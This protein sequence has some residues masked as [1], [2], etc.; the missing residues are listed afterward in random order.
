MPS[1]V[2]GLFDYLIPA[3]CTVQPVVGA[4]VKASFGKRIAIGVIVGLAQDSAY[5]VEKLKVITELLDNEAMLPDSMLQLCEWASSY[6]QYPLGLLLQDIMPTWLRTDHPNTDNPS[7]EFALPIINAPLQLNTAQTQAVAAVINHFGNFKSFLLDGIT[8]SGKTEVYMHLIA[9]A[10]QRGLQVLVLVPEINLTPQTLQRFQER[11]PVPIAVLHSQISAKKRALAWWQAK[12]GAAPI[13]LG[14]RLAAF[15]PLHNPG[16]FIIDE[17]HDS[18]FK[19]QNN[20]RY[21]ARDLLLKRAQLENCPIVLGSATPAL[22]TWHNAMHN[23]FTHIILPHRTGNATLPDFKIID[24]RNL[25]LFGGLSEPLLTII[26]QHLAAQNQVLIFLNRR[27]YAPT[28]LCYKCGWHQTCKNCDS[29]M[30]VHAHKNILR[31]H[32]C[33][34]MTKIPSTCPSCHDTEISPI[35][36]G[37]Q[38]LE[39]ALQEYFPHAKIAR[40]DS[41]T[42]HT[43]KQL[44]TTLETIHNKQVDIVIGT[45]M[46]AK[47]HHFANITL[48][49]IID[50]DA[51]LF[52]VDFRAIERA[53]QLITQVA[54][55]AGRGDKPGTVLLQ[56]TQPSHELL[57]ALANDGG[58]H[59][60]LQLL[61]NERKLA[62]LPPFSY[63]ILLRAESKKPNLADQFLQTTKQYLATKSDICHYGPIPAPMEKKQ[64]Y[65]RSLL[66][67]QASTRKILHTYVQQ[68]I[69]LL[70]QNPQARFIKWSLDV[71]PIDL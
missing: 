47:G 4:R 43:Q 42:V 64:G 21:S 71:D 10:L 35:G 61:Y 23:K 9:H 37:T 63:Q 36:I 32:H 67:L 11:F 2:R 66:L 45:Q 24:I 60:F 19:Q 28:L 70:E 7:R 5:P 65:Y 41:D 6:Y 12:T 56:T 27:G 1:P 22:E 68:I 51:A 58:Y 50:I 44:Y 34:A 49:A 20:L 53:G 13:V 62:Q 40:I 15:T 52:S 26:A 46:V 14:T 69:H 17:E 33:S 57:Q 8:G 16:L 29:N 3:S 55:R 18:S 25:K 39:Q 38:R 30:T 31:C 54:G 48:V 59:E